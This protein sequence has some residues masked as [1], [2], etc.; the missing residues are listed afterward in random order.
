M[1]AKKTTMTIPVIVVVVAALI[2]TAT[3]AKPALADKSDKPSSSQKSDNKEVGNFL[4][5]VF[6]HGGEDITKSK[7]RSCWNQFLK[8]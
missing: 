5:C 4:K 2:S 3:I 6:F 8:D 7:L 1:Y